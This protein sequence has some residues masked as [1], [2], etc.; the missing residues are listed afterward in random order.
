M[1]EQE[2]KQIILKF[3]RR[4]KLGVVSTVF[5]G[6]LMPESA[7]VSISETD[8]L[9][10]VFGS[11]KAERKNHNILANP[12]VSFVVGWDYE[13]KITVQVEARVQLLV[14]K[15]RE[16]LSDEHCKKHPGSLK[17]KDDPRQE[18]FKIVPHWIRYSNFACDPQK[19][20]ELTLGKI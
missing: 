20:W 6:S 14:G 8:N 16:A 7:V 2:K 19:I 11:F 5:P 18:Y 9:D 15:E 10:I 1:T 13:E 12:Q 17:Y 3:F 4:C